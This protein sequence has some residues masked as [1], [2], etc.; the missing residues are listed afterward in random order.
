[1]SATSLSQPCYQIHAFIVAEEAQDEFKA[2][3]TVKLRKT[4]QEV[5]DMVTARGWNKIAV[6]QT[7]NPMHRAHIELTKKALEAAPDMNL[8]IHPV[9]G[10]TRP[11]D[12]DYHTRVK[13]TN[14]ILPVVSLLMYC[15][16]LSPWKDSYIFM[17]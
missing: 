13:C 9:V 7:R 14:S 16:F 1:M 4:P 11:G 12:V 17:S 2:P 3:A 10:M 8:L 5:R 6:F 15:I